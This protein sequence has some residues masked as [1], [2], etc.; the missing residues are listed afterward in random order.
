[1]A[2][3]GQ[4]FTHFP[5]PL[6]V[7]SLTYGQEVGGMYRVEHAKLPGRNH[8]F[9]AAA[10]A[11][12]NKVNAFPYV[13]SELHQILLVGLLKQV[14]PFA[15]VHRPGI[16]VSGQELAVPLKVMQISMGALQARPTCIIL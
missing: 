13:F 6:Q 14:Q 2:S 7:A 3:T 15:H 10:T 4:A 16:T 1:M 8:G 9:A 12:A 11:V 5:Q